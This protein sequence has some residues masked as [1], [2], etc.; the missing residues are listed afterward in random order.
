MFNER[1]FVL[2]RNVGKIQKAIKNHRIW[3]N[4]CAG[5]KLWWF[6]IHSKNSNVCQIKLNCAK[7]LG[8]FL[9]SNWG[10]VVCTVIS[11]TV[12]QWLVPFKARCSW[13]QASVNPCVESAFTEPPV[14]SC[15]PIHR[16]PLVLKTTWQ[17]SAASCCPGTLVQKQFSNCSFTFI[18]AVSGL[19]NFK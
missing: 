8:G 14:E 11:R 10:I 18:Y 17:M 12:A 13:V 15:G 7:A 4:G 16:F 9:S 6:M 3:S 1:Q 19:Y 2:S 5:L